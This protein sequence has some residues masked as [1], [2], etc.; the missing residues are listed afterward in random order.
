MSH[1]S[2]ELKSVVL[3]LLV[4]LAGPASA[5]SLAED[6]NELRRQGCEG[7]SVA[8]PLQ[9]STELD[10]VARQWAR[11]GRLKDALATTGYRAKNSASMRI[12][13]AKSQAALLQALASNYC[14]TLTDPTFTTIGISQR[15]GHAH[16]VV[17][18]PVVPPAL[19]DASSIGKEVLERVNAA[20]SVPRKCGRTSFAAV[21]PLTTSAMLNRAALTHAQDMATRNFFEHEG[22]DGSTASARVSRTG[23]QWRSVGENIAAGPTTAEQV[24]G[25]WLDS[26]GHCANIMNGTFTEMGIAF[27]TNAKS[28][29]GIYWAQVFATPRR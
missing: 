28:D 11:G 24:V 9:A 5:A 23:Y 25:G 26:P 2:H 18:L 29:A 10:A 12:E 6:I 15:P 13:G 14:K 17:A 7:R 19:Q 16:I 4:V 8:A 20:R 1:W 27:A 21:P 22:S 3:V